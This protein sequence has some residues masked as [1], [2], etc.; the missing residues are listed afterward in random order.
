MA[1]RSVRLAYV[2]PPVLA[3]VL[4]FLGC[5]QLSQGGLVGVSSVVTV[6]SGTGAVSNR[7]VARALEQVAHE[8]HA[9]IA[10]T[11]ADR[12]EPTS[13]RTALVTDVPGTS[14]ATWLRD[15]YADFDPGTTTTVR[16]MSTLDRYDPSGAFEVIGDE[17]ARR[18]TV[19]AL[20]AAGFETTSERVPFPTR[21]GLTGGVAGATSLVGVLV[22][23]CVTLCLVGT[24]GA[25]RRTAVGRL[26]GR[27]TLQLVGAELG[28][29]RT[30]VVVVAV[31]SPVVAA[32]LWCHDRLAAWPTFA[33]AAVVACAALLV[34]VLAAHALGTVVDCRRPVAAAL[35]GARP[36]GVLVLVA[37]AA[38]VP[39]VLLLVAAVSDLGAAAAVAGSGSTERDR[40]AAGDTVQVWVTPDP[41]PGGTTQRYWDRIGAFTGAALDRHQALL[42]AAVEVPTGVGAG[43]VPAV[44]VDAGYLRRQDLRTAGGDR[45]TTVGDAVTVWTPAG[46]DRRAL[47]EALT[48]WELRGAPDLRHDDVGGGVLGRQQ[49]WTYPGDGTSAPWLSGAVVVVVPEPSRVFT[50]DQL[51]AWLSTGDVVFSSRA[52]ADAAIAHSGLSDEFS[53]V[54]AVG[55]AAAEQQRGAAT[56][57]GVGV[58]TTLAAFVVAVVLAALAVVA[59]HRRHG[60]LLFVDVAVG[61]SFVRA[62]AL[63]LAVEAALVVVA[64]VVA[65]DDWWD[66]RADGTGAVSALDPA[67]QVAGPA[68]V[69]AVLAVLV[70]TGAALV[71]T[72]RSSRAVVRTRGGTS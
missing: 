10:K 5:L 56:T 59:H 61:R 3:V 8:H 51:G 34:P 25:P 72:V 43:T 20:V 41:R 12:S 9:T 38:R 17:Q 29:A 67:A 31:G 69:G 45:V 44:F 57:L 7:A 26:H 70:V 22:L 16:P 4:A 50:A 54:V 39:A 63:L 46:L 53:A 27:G 32:V 23:G 24:V 33:T 42:S 30:T 19:R 21:I 1:I 49:V 36:P 68:A 40:R 18:A 15:G 14:G 6:S 66:R 13:R 48:A 52:A 37:Q 55:Q 28:E 2:V 65:L 71:V 11:V 35:R 64:T 60:R 47:V 58:V 62:N